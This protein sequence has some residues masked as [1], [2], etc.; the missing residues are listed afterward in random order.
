[1]TKIVEVLPDL[2]ALIDR[3]LAIVLDKLNAAVTE[4]GIGTIALAGG[5]TP[6]PLYEKLAA[7]SL[8]WDKIHVFWGDERYVPADHP[9]SNQ[10]MARLAWLD[11]VEIPAS[12][13]HPMATNEADPA[14]AAQTHAAELQAFFQVKATEFPAFDVI[15]LGI[16]DDAHTASLFPHTDALRVDD[17]LVTVGSKDGQPR[18]TFTVPLINHAQTVIFMVAGAS[19]QSALAQ[20]FAPVADDMTYPSRLI[21][22]QGDL[23]WLL[24]QS[25]GQNFKNEG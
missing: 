21:A 15:L 9:D 24:D 20:I 23:W 2:E 11:R 19:K 10:R 12:N 17:R 25:A 1:M 22:P 16:G 3:A 6:K 4:R 14:I 7:Q 8:P 5:S 13:V 18:I